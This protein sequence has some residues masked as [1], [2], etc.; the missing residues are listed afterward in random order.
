MLSYWSLGFP[1]SWSILK[2]PSDDVI[3][4][5]NASEGENPNSKFFELS[6][7]SSL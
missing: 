1:I 4:E 6:L 2:Y 5:F 3:V 7:V